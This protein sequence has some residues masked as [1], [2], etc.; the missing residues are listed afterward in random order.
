MGHKLKWDEIKRVVSRFTVTDLLSTI[1]RTIE[2]RRCVIFVDSL[3][4]PPT[5]F[6]ALE[7]LAQH[8]QI[9]AA[10]DS[11]NRRNRAVKFS[12]PFP[13]V[14]ELKP[15]PLEASEQLIR[16]HISASP[17][18]FTD[19]KTEQLFVRRVAQEGRGVPGAILGILNAAAG[20]DRITPAK[21]R[22]IQSEAAVQYLDVTPALEV[23]P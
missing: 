18:R 14:I 3:E 1:I 6:D 15:L 19:R 9:I 12:A 22:M 10:M 16:D 4:V 17:L 13:T 11:D 21:V 23:G 20:E 5:Y 2:G 7:E 8:A